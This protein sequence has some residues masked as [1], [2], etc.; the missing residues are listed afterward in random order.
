LWFKQ[1]VSLSLTEN[2]QLIISQKAGQISRNLRGARQD[3]NLF[4][5]ALDASSSVSPCIFIK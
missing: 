2:Q 5:V 4:W 3:K 1:G